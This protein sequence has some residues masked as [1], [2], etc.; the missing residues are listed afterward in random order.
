MTQKSS[1][2]TA[3]VATGKLTPSAAGA[4]YEP[5]NVLIGRWM[6]NGS[7]FDENDNAQLSINTVD[8]YNGFQASVLLSILPL[9]TPVI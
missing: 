4:E 1:A 3:N 2:D 9:V 8:I 7:T 6:T 5:L